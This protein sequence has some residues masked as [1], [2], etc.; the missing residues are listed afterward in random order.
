MIED[1]GLNDLGLRI[2]PIFRIIILDLL[3]SA[4]GSNA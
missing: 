4:L 2:F 3:V 1:A